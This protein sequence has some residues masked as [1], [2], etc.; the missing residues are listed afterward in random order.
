MRVCVRAFCCRT[1][2]T[3]W[4]SPRQLQ[5]TPSP[6]RTRSCRR[7]QRRRP[8]HT[9]RIPLPPTST[10]LS[11]SQSRRR[12]SLRDSDERD[13]LRASLRDSDDIDR[14]LRQLL[15]RS[16]LDFLTPFCLLRSTVRAR[17]MLQ[18]HHLNLTCQCYAQK[19][20]WN[21]PLS[22][23]SSCQP[24][25][26]ASLKRSILRSRASRPYPSG[27]AWSAS[28]QLAPRRLR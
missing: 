10:Y 15:L 14:F 11:L 21:M 6:P 7:R 27:R 1:T 8:P 18:H 19:L 13:S 26:P 28:P 12:E 5:A 4:R 25:V 24:P 16:A 2:R 22:N 23:A 9:V 20:C 3:R 17:C